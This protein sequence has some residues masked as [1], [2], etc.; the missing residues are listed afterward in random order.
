MTLVSSNSGTSICQ[1]IVRAFSTMTNTSSA[2]SCIHYQ[3]LVLDDDDIDDGCKESY[4]LLNVETITP[5]CS[6][7]AKIKDYRRHSVA[8]LLF[9][10][11]LMATVFLLTIKEKTIEHQLIV[12]DENDGENND[13]CT[14]D[15]SSACLL[16]HI[17]RLVRINITE[18]VPES[19]PQRIALLLE[20]PFAAPTVNNASDTEYLVITI[21]NSTLSVIL[22]Y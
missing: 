18:F 9:I 21:W 17:F 20:G 11:W 14:N 22:A 19:Q 12:V 1:C 16:M 2:I 13:L 7:D 6:D 4:G 15:H 8:V 5:N 10:V 3:F